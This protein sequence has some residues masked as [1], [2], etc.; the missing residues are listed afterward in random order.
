[1]NWRRR[2]YLHVRS[3]GI[4]TT[5]EVCSHE[6]SRGLSTQR[7]ESMSACTRQQSY[8]RHLGITDLGILVVGSD[9]VRSRLLRGG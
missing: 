3:S 2:E 7:A 6:L 4:P 8:L 5:G 9:P 1:M